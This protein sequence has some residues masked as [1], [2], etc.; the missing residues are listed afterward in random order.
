M[1]IG[2]SKKRD[3]KVRVAGMFIKTVLS[4]IAPIASGPPI[5]PFKAVF[6]INSGNLAPIFCFNPT[7]N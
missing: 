7:V 6:A 3:K 2:T 1:K 4:F 5:I